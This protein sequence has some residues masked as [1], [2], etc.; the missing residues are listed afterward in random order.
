MSLATDLSCSDKHPSQPSG[1]WLFRVPF[2][3]WLGTNT[4]VPSAEAGPVVEEAGAGH[5][6][7]AWP[8][9]RRGDKN[10]EGETQEGALSRASSVLEEVRQLLEP[11]GAQER[12]RRPFPKGERAGRVT[13]AH[14]PKNTTE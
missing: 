2:F 12:A 7:W 1:L 13:Q 11:G 5:G 3:M 10:Q 4:L 8:S 6:G 14:N 9:N